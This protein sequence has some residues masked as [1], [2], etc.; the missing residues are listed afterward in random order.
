LTRFGRTLKIEAMSES[1]PYPPTR[2]LA[3]MIAFGA[4]L[5]VL[6]YHIG[7]L[8]Q[9]L[10]AH[11]ETYVPVFLVAFA[12]YAAVS[13]LVWRAAPNPRLTLF[14]VGFAL[15]FRLIVVFQPPS[16]STD[17][18]RYVWDGHISAAGI[19][20]YRFAP[21]D[22]AL[23][24]HRTDFWPIINHPTWV[25]MYPPLSQRI[26]A[27]IAALGGA[28][29][30]AYKLVFTLFDLGCIGL[31]LVLLKRLNL[32]LQRVVL[33]AWHPLVIMEFAGSGHQDVLGVF[34]ML[35]ALAMVRR[36]ETN[37]D[38]VAG[39]FGAGLSL[40]AKGY[41]LPAL[42]IWARKKPF[43]FALAFGAT[44]A[45]LLLPYM[46]HDSQ[47]LIGMNKYL[48]NRLRNAGVF[49]WT[50][51]AL[52][53]HT[54]ITHP[55]P[56]FLRMTRLLMTGTLGIVVLCLAW[57]PWKDEADL[58]RRSVA[59]MG[60]FFILSHTVYPW[61]ATWLIPGFCFGAM[62]GWFAW[63]GLVSLA[64]LNP[65]PWKNAWVPYAEYLPV[66]AIFAG[67][68]IAAIRQRKRESSESARGEVKKPAP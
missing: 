62:P 11:P 68:G 28:A 35:L 43:W 60:T 56:Q 38:G 13:L 41:L 2:I 58:L 64:Y 48:Q 26:F 4:A 15:V 51:Q 55:Q 40:M 36:G 67:Q 24:A 53:P 57:K 20:P 66:L 16:L 59:A 61:Y 19:N 25:T 37:G 10:E 30:L 65:L 47:I 22:P 17:I 21:S 27:V 31:I 12:A 8:P 52:D 23:L 32:P 50:L 6:L 39:G 1:P 42:P 63:S 49:A 54:P 29:P 33:Y 9:R 46:G 7:Q 44:V 18:W 3:P 45:A 14:I 34:F 5:A